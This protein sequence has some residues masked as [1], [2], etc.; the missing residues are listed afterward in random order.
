[1]VPEHGTKYLD[2]EREKRM[3]KGLILGILLAILLIAGGAYFFISTG[4]PR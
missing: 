2:R 3:V 4:T 1:M